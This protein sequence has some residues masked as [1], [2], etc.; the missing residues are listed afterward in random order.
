MADLID[1]ALTFPAVV[2]SFML[3]VVVAYWVLVIVGGLGIDMLDGESAEAGAADFAAAVGLRGVPVTVSLSLII[4]I[5]W[6]A[7]LSATVALG[8]LDLPTPATVALGIVAVALAVVIAWVITSLVVMFIRRTLP[9]I[10][11]SSRS[12]FVGK[13]CVIRTAPLGHGTG[14]AEVTA[15]DGSTA[16]IHVRQTG[17]DEFL[18]GSTALIFDYD[19]DGEFFWVSPFAAEL[20]PGGR[21]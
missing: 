19:S 3:L 5:A 18:S 12:D 11:E 1:H 7:A 6:F 21:L 13:I 17:D 16:I 2:F 20:D 15:D 9:Q 4:A 14:Q 8:E 10:R